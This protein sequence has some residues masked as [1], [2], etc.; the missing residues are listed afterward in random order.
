MDE[1]SSRLFE[2]VGFLLTVALTRRMQNRTRLL[3][4]VVAL[5]ATTAF[6]PRGADGPPPGKFNKLWPVN[7]MSLSA[8]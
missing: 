7:G 3:L 2:V 6:S 8:I 5:F 4:V 1:T